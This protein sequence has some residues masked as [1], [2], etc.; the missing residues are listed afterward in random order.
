[1]SDQDCHIA[2]IGVGSNLPDGDSLLAEALEWIRK[3]GKVS[4]EVASDLYTTKPCGGIGRDYF[5]GVARIS[6]SYTYDRLSLYFKEIEARFGSVRTEG[7]HKSEAGEKNVPVDIDVVIF[8]SEIKRPLDYSRSYFQIGYLRIAVRRSPSDSGFPVQGYTRPFLFQRT[9]F[10]SS[11]SAFL[12]NSLG[13]SPWKP[14]RQD[15]IF[16]TYAV[17]QCPHTP[18][19]ITA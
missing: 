6:T 14:V 11:L 17:Q 8:D 5:N 9:A 16:N 7:E 10:D 15:Y 3:D 4:I 2:Y 1:M 19:K 13:A 12:Q 18:R